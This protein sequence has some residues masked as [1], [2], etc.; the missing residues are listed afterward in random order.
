MGEM[1]LLFRVWTTG[2]NNVAGFGQWGKIPEMVWTMGEIRRRERYVSS[3][4]LT[5]SIKP[6]YLSLLMVP[7]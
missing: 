3:F 2:E 7:Y 6:P 5:T 1:L 4:L